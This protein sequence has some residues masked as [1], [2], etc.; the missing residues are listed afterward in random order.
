MEIDKKKCIGCGSCAAMHPDVF[1]ISDD[2]FS[3]VI[4]DIKDMDLDKLMEMAE[5]CPV[6]AIQIYDDQDNLIYPKE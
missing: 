1:K 5:I 4:A 6:M 2:G 3:S